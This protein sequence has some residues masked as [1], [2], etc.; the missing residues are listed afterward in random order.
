MYKI[1]I[2]KDSSYAGHYDTITIEQE[3]SSVSI[4]Y[5]AEGFMDKDVDSKTIKLPLTEYCPIA[6]VFDNLDFPKI[7]AEN[8]V[9]VGYYGWILKCTISNGMTK[10]SVS[11]W[12]PSEDPSK[13]DTTKLLQACDK[14]CALFGEEL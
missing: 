4:K 13:P 1:T 12:C 8:D 6:N 2:E 5:A 3:K 10:V 11:L 9:L 7:L 14:I